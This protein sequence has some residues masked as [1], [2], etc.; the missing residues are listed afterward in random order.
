M[1]SDLHF[2]TETIIPTMACLVIEEKREMHFSC[3][4]ELL[5]RKVKQ[6]K[7]T[8]QQSDLSLSVCAGS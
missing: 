2:R 8:K 5:K 4:L 6:N 1:E 7:N 3:P